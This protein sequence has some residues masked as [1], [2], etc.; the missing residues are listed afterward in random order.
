MRYL[1]ALCAIVSALALSPV[2]GS[3]ELP[4][5]SCTPY[6][7]TPVVSQ[8]IGWAAFRGGTFNCGPAGVWNSYHYTLYIIDYNAITILGQK[9]GTTSGDVSFNNVMEAYC[10]RADGTGKMVQGIAVIEAAGQWRSASSGAVLCKR[11]GGTG[12]VQP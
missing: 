2:A 6:A 9:S 3:S 12:P 10:L 7:N 8:H 1:I 4:A 5:A 11:L